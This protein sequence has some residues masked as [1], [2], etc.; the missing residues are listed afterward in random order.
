[1]SAE[2]LISPADAT[3][4]KCGRL[5][6]AHALGGQCPACVAAALLSPVPPAPSEADETA[7]LPRQFGDY[8][9]LA[10]VARGGMGV[11]YRA[12]QI[13]LNRT[14]AVK[15][16]LAGQLSGDAAVKRFRAEATAV[17][18]LQHPGIVAAHEV[19]EISGTHFFSMA[20]V[21]G[22]NLAEL[23]RTAPLPARR[24][25]RYVW[26]AAEAIEHAHRQGVIHRD[27]KPSNLLIDQDDRVRVTDFGVACCLEA[28]P[29]ATASGAVLG[30]PGYMSPEQA[31]GQRSRLGPAADVYSLGAT[32]YALLTG[33]PPFQAD[34]PLETLR[35]VVNELPA[36]PRVLNR[37]IPT[38]LE[39]VAL[40]CLHKEPTQRYAS[41]QALADDLR[42]FLDGQPVHARPSG[43]L[44]RAWR[45]ARRNP[46]QA[47]LSLFA[48][49]LALVLV[50]AATLRLADAQSAA[51]LEEQRR[52]AA[53]NLIQ[54]DARHQAERMRIELREL[55][56]PV[57]ELARRDTNLIN[58]LRRR[59]I[60]AAAEHMQRAAKA[61]NA[62]ES[63]L[64]WFNQTAPFE[65]W[66]LLDTDG[67]L[68][69][70]WPAM[71]TNANF[72]HR[73]Y[74][75]GAFTN[76][77]STGLGAVHVS[78]AFKSRLD[79]QHKIGLS[80]AVTDGGRV[81]GVVM[82]SLSTA[83]TT[84]LNDDTRKAALLARF[85]PEL[86]DSST[87]HLA[88]LLHEAY[89]AREAAAYEVR[90]EAVV[91]P[92]D[93]FKSFPQPQ[94]GREL[95]ESTLETS[96]LAES[97][98]LDPVAKR[99]SKY[100]GEWLAGLAAVGNTGLLLVYQTRPTPPTAEARALARDERF[101]KGAGIGLLGV[102]VISGALFGIWRWNLWR[103]PPE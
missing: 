46:A 103:R 39:T 21:E 10:E 24:A 96:S 78:Q 83:G 1:M 2:T 43:P 7:R 45:W 32:L 70:R 12:R 55:S 92:A 65:S 84:P 38:D 17:A 6:P 99:F 18:R 54:S 74:F 42:R 95:T 35:Q 68:L 69:A 80:A 82:A 93:R 37:N 49:L 94:V 36:R 91:F 101:W 66:F 76:A 88:V 31:S 33:R 16:I 5:L 22:R 60:S 79:R 15:M 86:E 29:D 71:V 62:G 102:A 13:S 56:R 23:S 27:V 67:T 98:Y 100:A 90:K 85:D 77:G 40:K 75:Q 8:E 73:D 28:G 26:E 30:T 63:D 87:N 9:L 19:G 41:A 44:Y 97:A 51:E 53:L 4:P 64:H 47:A 34:T 48:G 58:A 14:V 11:V 25:A 61:V 72:K 20:F 81:L 59:D 57:W 89:E 50:S 52:A 3:C